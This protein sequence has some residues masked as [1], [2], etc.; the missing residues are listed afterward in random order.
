MS[1][2]LTSLSSLDDFGDDPQ[3]DSNLNRGDDELKIAQVNLKQQGSERTFQLTMNSAWVD[4]LQ[5][6]TQRTAYIPYQCYAASKDC[7]SRCANDF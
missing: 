4:A 7:R 2:P 3:H 5:F 1:S 6:E